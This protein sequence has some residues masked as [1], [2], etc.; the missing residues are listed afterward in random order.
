MRGIQYGAAF[1][2]HHERR[3]ILDHPLSRMMTAMFTVVMPRESGVSSTARL[4][5]SI[6]SALE[7]WIA[8]FRGRR[9]L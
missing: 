6:T 7:Y 5:D 1:R 2:F 9:P 8:R 4:F 3:G